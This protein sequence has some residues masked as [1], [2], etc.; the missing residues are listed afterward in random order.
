M[1]WVATYVRH[2]IMLKD[3]SKGDGETGNHIIDLAGSIPIFGVEGEFSLYYSLGGG[4]HFE[5]IQGDSNGN[6]RREWFYL[7][8]FQ[9][10]DTVPDD[11]DFVKYTP[12]SGHVLYE[13]YH[14]EAG[15]W[16]DAFAQYVATLV[17]GSTAPPPTFDSPVVPPNGFTYRAGE[18]VDS[19]LGGHYY[20]N[21]PLEGPH[22]AIPFNADPGAI[23]A[24][25]DAIVAG[26]AGFLTNL[27]VKLG[28]APE[29]IG[30]DVEAAAGAI[31]Q[32]VQALIGDIALLLDE[33]GTAGSD[34][35]AYVPARVLAFGTAVEQARSLLIS[36]MQGQVEN[37]PQ[38][39][40]PLAY[41]DV[42]TLVTVA[43]DGSKDLIQYYGTIPTHGGAEVNIIIGNDLS[44]AYYGGGGN[45]VLLGLGGADALDGEGDDDV[46]FG[47]DGA[48]TLQGNVGNDVLIGGSGAD[49][50]DGYFGDDIFFVDDKGDQVVEE[51]EP[52]A[53]GTN[54][55]IVIASVTFDL[56]GGVRVERLVTIDETAT[57]KINL[58][59]NEF[60]QE[61]V[62]NAGANIISDGGKG[63]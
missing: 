55:D 59:G 3:P 36:D 2:D 32:N 46:L 21:G 41:L 28:Q 19:G 37:S 62:G 15:R 25:A 17:D 10:M 14:Y 26:A 29:D 20:P 52:T 39:D 33:A 11:S 7:Q 30:D 45:D 63:G 47:G 24:A 12:H 43:A 5:N 9:Q 56:L 18:S 53:E 31:E 51:F 49:V 48:D 16:A 4:F 6:D 22:V 27:G 61:I 23:D 40:F 57:T 60:A 1:P 58:Y 34:P 44:N 35:D 13:A 50:M 42:E 8:S 54:F 38:G